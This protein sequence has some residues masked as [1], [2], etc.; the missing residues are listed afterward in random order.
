MKNSE[1][2]KFVII[3][4][5]V[6]FSALQIVEFLSYNAS[7]NHNYPITGIAQLD[8]K[9]EPGPHTPEQTPQGILL[10]GETT[11]LSGGTTSTRQQHIKGMANIAI[12]TQQN[13]TG[14]ARI[15]PSIYQK[16]TPEMERAIAASQAL[17]NEIA[18]SVN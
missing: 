13:I 14:M 6:G 8:F 9:F 12:G 3:L 17:I 7:E 1:V 18:D 4:L 10:F 15:A 16:P 2:S 5:L 11:A